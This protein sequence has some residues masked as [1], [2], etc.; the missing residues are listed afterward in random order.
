MVQVYH[1]AIRDIRLLQSAPAPIESSPFVTPRL[2]SM[3]FFRH[4]APVCLLALLLALIAAP[5]LL[6]AQSISDLTLQDALAAAMTQSNAGEQRGTPPYHTSSWLAGLPSLSL[7]YLDSDERYGTD[8]AE[9]SLN[10]PVKSGRRRNADKQ[11]GAL[12][13]EL[14]EINQRQRTLYYSGLIREAVWSYRLVDTRRR[15]AADKRQLLL[16]LER[17]QSELVA[18]SAASQYSLLLLQM[19]LVDVEIAQQDYLHESRRWLDRYRG[20]TGLGTLPSDIREP[21]APT[22]HFQSDQQPQLRNLELAH[23][24]RL[25]LLRAG[26][27]Q[28]SDWNLSL[29]AKNLDT[30]GYDEQQYGLAVEIPLSAL[31][32]S[33]Q[34]ENSEWRNAQRDYLLARDQLL[35]KVN[36]SWEKLLLEQETL[37]QKQ[38]L[39]DRSNTL[40]GRIAAQLSQL[41]ASNEI[42]QEILLR[43]MM[44]A[45][46]TRTEV[47]VNQVL[48]DQ[49]NAMLRQAAGISL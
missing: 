49:N 26:S 24:Q 6:I 16:E 13:L 25:Q 21:T 43:R 12:A 4:S 18:A 11:L 28:A 20:I 38:L 19:E 10:L 27:A 14:D 31:P 41:Q 33:R 36:D 22:D 1:T 9:V 48:I 7:S 46:D 23:R 5:Q 42:A 34:A 2:H 32:V 3:N 17:R 29:H 45:I 30:A 44:G 40:A 39:L 8:E 47:A 15:F 35:R 37:R